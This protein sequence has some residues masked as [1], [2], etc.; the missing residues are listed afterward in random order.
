MV[1]HVHRDQRAAN[2]GADVAGAAER[3]LHIT[4]RVCVG[5][6]ADRRVGV[7]A[8][9]AAGAV[10]STD[11]HQVILDVVRARVPR[12]AGERAPDGFDLAV[13]RRE[14][15]ALVAQ[16]AFEALA[17]DIDVVANHLVALR[18]GLRGRGGLDAILRHRRFDDRRQR[19]AA[20]AI[21]QVEVTGFGD[22]RDTLARHAVELGVEQDR[23]V[24]RV[25]IP[26]I[27]AHELEVP[28]IL[29]CRDVEREHRSREQ[30][31][32]RADRAVQVGA[33][34]AGGEVDHPE[35]GV[36]ARRL[37]HR[38]SA[39][40]P[41][42]VVL[43][44]RGMADFAGTW[45]R[46]EV[47]NLLAGMRIVRADAAANRVFAAREAGDD[48]AIVVQRRRGDAV[49][50][51]RIRREHVPD[52]LPGLLVERDEPTVEPAE[53]KHAVAKPEAAAQTAAADDG[54]L[55][56]DVAFVGPKELAAIDVHGE[57]VVIAGNDIEHT[58]VEE[59]LCLV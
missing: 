7:T 24:W 27:V 25:I 6:G 16:D 42:V 18:N 57:N 11:V 55:E 26:N 45:D 22:G 8:A 43:R 17:H 44:P 2:V 28:A 46:P 58:F 36:D 37:P 59:R 47:P 23:R 32:T 13:E 21:E 49:A 51:C 40:L 54:I 33:G 19:Y 20:G 53:K 3:A 48:H 12:D 15:S 31:V 34:I 5:L 9:A 39:V 10:S 1:G 14:R 56:I 35:L 30:V 52:D 38:R 4:A 50:Q 41:C 29:T